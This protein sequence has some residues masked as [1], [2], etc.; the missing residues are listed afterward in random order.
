MSDFAPEYTSKEKV[1]L[2]FKHMAWAIPLLLI[3]QFWF[4][5][6]FTAFSANASCYDFG[7]I[8][9]FQV[10]FYGICVGCPLA[11]ALIFSVIEGP[12]S[13]KIIRLA[14]Y[15]LPNEKVLGR[16]RYV[17]GARA[18]IRAYFFFSAI[19]ALLSLAI[20]GF[21]MANKI[22]SGEPPRN[23]NDSEQIYSAP[24]R[25]CDSEQDGE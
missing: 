14:Q 4:L 12:R 8:S 13:L 22:L 3:G 25:S 1:L 2:V 18:K 17:Y 15:P 23:I 24:Q 19:A 5:P 9:G 6:W 7:K 11:T 21:F 10:L 16:T 20:V